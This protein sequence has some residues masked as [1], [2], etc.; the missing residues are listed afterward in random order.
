MSRFLGFDDDS[1]GGEN[2][3]TSDP[4]GRSTKCAEETDWALYTL[5]TVGVSSELKFADKGE[6]PRPP[7]TSPA[8][9]PM[10]SIVS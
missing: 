10:D 6:R 5:V 9:E 3:A 7:T 8:V 2:L 4:S 1:S